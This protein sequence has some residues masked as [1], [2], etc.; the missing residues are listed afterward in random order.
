M[1]DD[2]NF[3]GE[4]APRAFNGNTTGYNYHFKHTSRSRLNAKSPLAPAV[5]GECSQTIN[6]LA[7]LGRERSRVA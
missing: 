2:T 5:R 1:T 7:A 3:S 6:M 4:R